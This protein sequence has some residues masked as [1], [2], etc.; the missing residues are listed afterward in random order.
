MGSEGSVGQTNPGRVARDQ[1]S[2]Q[3]AAEAE[4]VRNVGTERVWSSRRPRLQGACWPPR[5][6]WGV[7]E[8]P[9]G[10]G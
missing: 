4:R 9:G 6:E 3:V 2:G 10:I 5:P 8:K 1:R 7:K